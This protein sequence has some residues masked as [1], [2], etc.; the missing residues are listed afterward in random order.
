MTP[1]EMTQEFHNVFQCAVDERT[2]DVVESRM[3]LLVEEYHEVMDELEY[4]LSQLRLGQEIENLPALAK[5]L[6]DLVYI[7]NGTAVALGID[8]D[9]A[10]QLV[11]QSNMTK[12]WD[13]G[14]PRWLPS[15]KVVKGPNYQEPD[16]TPTVKEL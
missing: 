12:L 2:E 9:K 16:M 8:L 4:A 13:D 14:L 15:G 7:A 5:E 3:N 6:A 1:L 10:V 11:H